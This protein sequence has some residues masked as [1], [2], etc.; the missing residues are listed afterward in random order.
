LRLELINDIRQNN[1][2][3]GIEMVVEKA[4]KII[5]RVVFV[6]FC[7]DKGLLPADKLKEVIHY[8]EKALA[9]VWQ[10]LSNFFEAVNSGSPKLEIPKG[11]N[12]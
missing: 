7:E 9:P 11:Y 12:G 3:L 10:T 8:G 4:Q 1:A 2:D 5:D 6:H